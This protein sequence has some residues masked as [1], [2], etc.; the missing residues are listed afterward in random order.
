MSNA[1]RLEYHELE[2]IKGSN[3]PDRDKITLWYKPKDTIKIIVRDNESVGN[4]RISCY[5]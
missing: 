3:K 1:T 2:E 5:F 4:I